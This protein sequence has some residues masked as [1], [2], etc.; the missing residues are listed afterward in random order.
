MLKSGNTIVAEYFRFLLHF[1]SELPRISIMFSQ[2]PLKRNIYHKRASVK[3]EQHKI[4]I[5]CK[6]AW[7]T[8]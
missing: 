5:N 3:L 2:T 6:S 7:L 1:S 8:K 4:T